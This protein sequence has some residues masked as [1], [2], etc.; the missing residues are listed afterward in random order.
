[1]EGMDEQ[2]TEKYVSKAE[3]AL[4]MIKSKARKMKN[5]GSDTA[6]QLDKNRSKTK[7]AIKEWFDRMD[8]PEL[9][10]DHLKHDVKRI[11][12]DPQAT[13]SILKKRLQRMDRES[14]IALV[15]N[16]Q[17]VDRE[18]AEKVVDK[19][20]QG[21]D[22]ILKK[23]DEIESKLKETTEKAKQEAMR[24]IEGARKTAAVLAWWIF[25]AA[26]LSGGASALGGILTP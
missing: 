23:V 22:E 24:Q 6:S 11:M 26:V 4:E 3:E 18:Q 8:Q 13:P 19:I 5:S 9:K 12:D 15:S 7:Q 2:K 14:L 1:M 17:K 10:Y 21:R 20:E 16:N 25:L